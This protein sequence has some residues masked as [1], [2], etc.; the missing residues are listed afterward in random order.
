MFPQNGPVES[1]AAPA[2]PKSTLKKNKLQPFGSHYVTKL[3][4]AN[5]KL[6]C[7]LSAAAFCDYITD[8]KPK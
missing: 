5:N 6:L 7:S 4:S 2:A 3:S 8:R 1:P